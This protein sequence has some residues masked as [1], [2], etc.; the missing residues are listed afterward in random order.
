MIEARERLLPTTVPDNTIQDWA[1]FVE[2][3]MLEKRGDRT[4]IANTPHG[5]R[6]VTGA[7]FNINLEPGIHYEH[8]G[9][10]H[11]TRVPGLE[12]ETKPKLFRDTYW[13]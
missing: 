3:L 10:V 6:I 9:I 1:S 13:K 4:W 7:Y 8:E 2:G 11:A 12:L 5:R